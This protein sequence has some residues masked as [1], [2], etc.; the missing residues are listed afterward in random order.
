MENL[1]HRNEFIFFQMVYLSFF[2]FFLVP[3]KSMNGD[4]PN[5]PQYSIRAALQQRHLWIRVALF[6][7]HLAKIVEHLH[8]NCG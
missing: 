1:K 6:E 5:K 7:K 3:R 4:S 8:E 2:F